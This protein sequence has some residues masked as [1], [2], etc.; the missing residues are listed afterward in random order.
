LR[1]SRIT[2]ISDLE[3][4]SIIINNSGLYVVDR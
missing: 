4:C 3:S 2:S 1:V